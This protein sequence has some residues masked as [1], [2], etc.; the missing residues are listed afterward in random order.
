MYILLF[1][2]ILL[3][4]GAFA[5]SYS[6]IFDKDLFS[7]NQTFAN[8]ITVLILGSVIYH[9]FQR[10]YYLPFLGPTV[11]P[12]PSQTD[13]FV[14]GKVP[15]THLLD[16]KLPLTHLLDGKLPL[17]HLLDGKLPDSDSANKGSG[18]LI[19]VSLSD[20]PANTRVLFWAAKSNL[21]GVWSNPIDA[22]QGYNNS[23]LAKTDDTGN[24][25]IQVNCPSDYKISK[26]GFNKKLSKHVHY[27]YE[28][29]KYPGIFSSVKT[30]YI[31]C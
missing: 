29:P 15:L 8:I 2:K 26:F 28:L 16:G 17:T 3:I 25:T 1:A 23:G 4:V 30:K 24:V 22:Y 20:I 19:Q 21:D 12:V 10:D 13:G 31:N 5:Y 27:R 6:K 11:I 7:F 14:I 18:E 9:V